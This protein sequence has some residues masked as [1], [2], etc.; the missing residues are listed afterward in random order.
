MLRHFSG[1]YK[2]INRIQKLLIKRSKV[3][4]LLSTSQYAA[5]GVYLGYCYAPYNACTLCCGL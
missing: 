4:L 2:F 5:R 1:E 3:D